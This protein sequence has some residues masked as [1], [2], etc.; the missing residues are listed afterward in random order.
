MVNAEDLVVKRVAP[1]GK[2]GDSVSGRERMPWWRFD[3]RRQRCK[4]TIAPI[5]AI[6]AT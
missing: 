2:R 5:M 1:A 4:S 6:I 3:D